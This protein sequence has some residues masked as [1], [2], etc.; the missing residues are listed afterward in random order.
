[1]TTITFEHL[2]EDHPMYGPW[3]V[4]CT[5]DGKTLKISV[6]E[7][8]PD[9]LYPMLNAVGAADEDGLRKHVAVFDVPAPVLVPAV[10]STPVKEMAPVWDWQRDEEGEILVDEDGVRLPKV[11]TDTMVEVTTTPSEIVVPAVVDERKHHDIVMWGERVEA[12]Y[13]SSDPT[14]EWANGQLAWHVWSV[15]W[16]LQGSENGV[17]NSNEQWKDLGGVS[18]IFPESIKSR[19]HVVA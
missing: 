2:P 14:M 1:M 10:W 6:R 7:E 4:P 11:P 12:L 19:S 18:A 15:M 3:V 17:Q 9:S 13:Y 5:W 16:L 8:Q